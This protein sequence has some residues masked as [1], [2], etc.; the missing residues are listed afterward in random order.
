[1][2]VMLAASDHVGAEL[3]GTVRGSVW[4]FPLQWPARLRIGGWYPSPSRSRGSTCCSVPRD[5]LPA[6][7]HQ[8]QHTSKWRWSLSL[9][10][11][12]WR[13]MFDGPAMVN[14]AHWTW[15]A[16]EQSGSRTP[17]W[18]WRSLRAMCLCMPLPTG[19]V[20]PDRPWC[21]ARCSRRPQR[22]AARIA[23]RAC[24]AS[25]RSKRCHAGRPRFRDGCC[26]RHPGALSLSIPGLCRGLRD[27]C[28]ARNRHMSRAVAF[29]RSVVIGRGSAVSLPRP[30]PDSGHDVT[31]GR[32]ST[33]RRASHGARQAV[34]PLPRSHDS[35]R[36]LFTT[37]SPRRTA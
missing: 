11:S 16:G 20:V 12:S 28:V 37:S 32:R 30:S 27:A 36:G 4:G 33:A 7:S 23:P 9:P 1:M 17:S 31:S 13:G 14:T 26:V 10:F 15:G 3:L 25:L 8:R 19:R 6:C 5:V 29:V 34:S 22:F 21:R 35:R 18:T 24:D 2:G